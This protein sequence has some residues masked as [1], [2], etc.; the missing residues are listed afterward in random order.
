MTSNIPP[1]SVSGATGPWSEAQQRA[2]SSVGMAARC[3]GVDAACVAMADFA[4]LFA[5]SSV[6]APRETHAL[7][8]LV[9]RIE[10]LLADESRS[11]LLERARNGRGELAEAIAEANATLTARSSIR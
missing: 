3:E 10:C 11:E 4:H 9:L 5:P 6:P 8:T 7:E 1:S 2:A